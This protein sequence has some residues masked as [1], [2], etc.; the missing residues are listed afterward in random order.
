MNQKN[1]TVLKPKHFK[2]LN[3]YQHLNYILKEIAGIEIP[4]QTLPSQWGLS[5]INRP[6]SEI[7]KKFPQFRLIILIFPSFQIFNNF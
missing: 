2:C 3:W 5:I 6:K 4:F 1:K 7:K